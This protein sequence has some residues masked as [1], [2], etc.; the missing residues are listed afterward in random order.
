MDEMKWEL[1]TEVQGRRALRL[2]GQRHAGQST[3]G[4]R[5]TVCLGTDGRSLA[6]AFDRG[7]RPAGAPTRMN[8]AQ[9]KGW[10]SERSVLPIRS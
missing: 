9:K 6:A 2:T 10:A 1:L 3:S 7:Y 5:P 4:G 8:G